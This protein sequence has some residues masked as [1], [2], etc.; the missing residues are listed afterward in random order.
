[1]PCSCYQM[2]T[3][4]IDT[5]EHGAHSVF[6]RQSQLSLIAKSS[7]TEMLHRSTPRAQRWSLSQY[8][9]LSASMLAPACRASHGYSL[10]GAQ[11]LTE[12]R[13]TRMQIQSDTA[14]DK[15]SVHASDPRASSAK[16]VTAHDDVGVGL[17]QKM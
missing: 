8:D 5:N 12:V 15:R 1:M 16:Y 4:D 7:H 2:F 9:Q 11:V 10:D 3:A 13:E 6:R 14:P 17:N